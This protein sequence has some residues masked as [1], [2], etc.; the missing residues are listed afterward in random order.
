MDKVRVDHPPMSYSNFL[1]HKLMLKLSICQYLTK[2]WKLCFLCA[3]SGF[4]STCPVSVFYHHPLLSRGSM[5]SKYRPHQF[6]CLRN[7][8]G[9]GLPQTHF[10]PGNASKDWSNPLLHQTG[11]LGHCNNGHL[12]LHCRPRF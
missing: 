1:A 9:N 10:L 3:V 4:K 12:L 8:R 2:K 11:L 5:R 6:E 7:S